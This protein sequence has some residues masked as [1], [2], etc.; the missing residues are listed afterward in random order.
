MARTLTLPAF[1][2]SC[3]SS[4]TPMN[5][6]NC[7]SPINDS[8]ISYF[9]RYLSAFKRLSIRYFLLFSVSLRKS[10][11]TT[12]Q[13]SYQCYD[14]CERIQPICPQICYFLGFLKES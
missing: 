6:R 7:D 12:P 10:L 3:L 2:G 8:V 14:Q 4:T 11:T 13:Q 9:F 5:Q 1:S